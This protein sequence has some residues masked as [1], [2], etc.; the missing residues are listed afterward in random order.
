M[1]KSNTEVFSTLKNFLRYYLIERN[2]EQTLTLVTDDIC[3]IV[4]TEETSV[5]GKSNFEQTM[6]DYPNKAGCMS[7]CFISHYLE[8]SHHE[9]VYECFCNVESTYS[10]AQEEH[11]SMINLL[12]AT[13]IK[14]DG[15]MKICTIHMSEQFQAHKEIQSLP[16]RFA[17]LDTTKLNKSVQNELMEIIAKTLPGGI[18]GCYVKEKYPIYVINDGMLKMLGFTYDEFMEST[19]GFMEHLIHPDDS[20]KV[21]DVI[22]KTFAEHNEYEVEY[23]LKKSDGSYI[24]IYDVGRKIVVEN[25]QDAI[26][27]VI[28]DISENVRIKE[29]L[30]EENMRDHLTNLYNRKAGEVLISDQLK[31]NNRFIFM[32]M[33]IDYFKQVNDIYGHCV[34]D[35]ILI[36]LSKQLQQTFRNTDVIARLGGDEFI[37]YIS[38]SC[39]VDIVLKK[40]ELVSKNYKDKVKELCP[41]SKSTLSIGGVFGT[42]TNSF[43]HI[44]HMA[45]EI[46]YEIKNEEKGRIKIID[47]L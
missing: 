29:N 16:V 5:S 7:T 41:Q 42:S 6:I 24:W 47:I 35:E 23:R 12:T 11:S 39:G 38:S 15:M 13:M 14:E 36:Y 44:Y 30:I 26:I 32:I 17:S 2:I 25:G 46:L 18:I 22:D 9:V 28:I 20:Q 10:L 21:S 33:D 40:L 34:G 43:Q 1:Q 31:Q 37:L 19:Q 27:C 3:L 4:G 45:D 8:K